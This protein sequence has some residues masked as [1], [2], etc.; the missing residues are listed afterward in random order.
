MDTT[1]FLLQ[2]KM[3]SYLWNKLNYLPEKLTKDELVKLE[4]FLLHRKFA[5]STIV[6]GKSDGERIIKWCLENIEKSIVIKIL[7]HSIYNS[8]KEYDKSYKLATEIADTFCSCWLADN[9]YFGHGCKSNINTTITMCEKEIERGKCLYSYWSLAYI[10]NKESDKRFHNEEKALKLMKIG[11]E[12][13]CTWCTQPL[14]TYY[15][16]KCDHIHNIYD[17]YVKL[18]TKYK[19]E[20]KKMFEDDQFKLMCSDDPKDEMMKYIKLLVENDLIRKKEIAD[21][22]EA[23]TKISSVDKLK[24]EIEELKLENKKLTKENEMLKKTDWDLVEQ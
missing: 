12:K 23:L 7:L 22:Q 6:P 1:F 13:E 21:L 18:I 14:V 16:D 2:Q 17:N 4:E 11:Q 24:L 10:Y 3:F 9:I 8:L 19:D 20:G 5:Y 15:N